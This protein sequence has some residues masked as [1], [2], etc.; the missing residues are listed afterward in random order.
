MSECGVSSYI[1]FC[2]Q[3]PLAIEQWKEGLCEQ[4]AV[5][6]ADAEA[7]YSTLHTTE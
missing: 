2:P 3:H 6:V 7:L 4:A 1:D 5:A